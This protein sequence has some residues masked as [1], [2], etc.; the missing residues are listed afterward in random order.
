MSDDPLAPLK[1]RFRV[2]CGE[3]AARLRAHLAGVD[4]PDLEGLVHRLAGA[5][6]TFG[7]ADISEA[8]LA[9]DDVYVAGG[10]PAAEALADLADRLE[11]LAAL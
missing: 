1:A 7:Y 4:E 2:R 5:A 9:I 6:G 10:A 8:A 11:T 3:D